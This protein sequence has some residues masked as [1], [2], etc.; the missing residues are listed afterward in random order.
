LI[1]WSMRKDFNER[2]DQAIKYAASDFDRHVARGLK[3]RLELR[4]RDA[5]EE[6]RQILALR[7]QDREALGGVIELLSATSQNELMAKPLAL[8][9]PHAFEGTDWAMIYLNY[10]HRGPNIPLA[11]DNAAKLAARWPD[12]APVAYQAHRT[13]LWDR[14]VE[15][16][17]ALAE[18]YRAAATDPSLAL[19]VAARQAAAEGRCAEVARLLATVPAASLVDRWHVLMLLGRREEAAQ[20]LMPLE[21]SGNTYALV[22]FLNYRQFDPTPYPSLMQVLAREKIQRPPPLPLPFACAK[23]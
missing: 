9:L 5:L 15:A 21:R 12:D 2:I 4:L 20:V 23:A 22:G 1:A 16:A 3:A 7:P 8:V 10:G 14:R 6:Q 19:I 18:R 11:A 13:L 17:R